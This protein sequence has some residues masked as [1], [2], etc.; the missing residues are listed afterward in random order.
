MVRD[1]SQDADRG[2]WGR[3][4]GGGGLPLGGAGIYQLGWRRSGV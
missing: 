1:G 4:G 3:R 2:F